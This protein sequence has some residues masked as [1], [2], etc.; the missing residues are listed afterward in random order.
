[1]DWWRAKMYRATDIA[2][3]FIQKG[4][5]ENKPITSMKVLKLTYIAQGLHLAA[6]NE[7]LYLESCQAW[8]YGP[9]VLPVYHLTKRHKKQPIVDCEDFK[10]SK[11][12]Y[13]GDNATI[14]LLEKVWKTFG[15]W[16]ALDLSAWSHREGSAWDKAYNEDGGKNY[17]GFDIAADLLKNEFSKLLSSP[18]SLKRNARPGWPT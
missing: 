18:S 3:W 12:I 2:K 4:I 16:S 1:M 13:E 9:V 7:A 14:S 15:S 11:G 17:M 8:Q 5:E 6:Y 10:D